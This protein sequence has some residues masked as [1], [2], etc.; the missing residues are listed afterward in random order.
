MWGG[1]NR[2]GSV[3][4]CFRL[5]RHR[6]EGPPLLGHAHPWSVRGQ[7][8][9]SPHQSSCCGLPP[10]LGPG[11]GELR[12]GPAT[13]HQAEVTSTPPHPRVSSQPTKQEGAWAETT[14]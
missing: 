14:F 10:E 5:A 2:K 12:T 1:G 9:C 3:S 13:L 8:G 6:A 4:E 7:Q 11:A